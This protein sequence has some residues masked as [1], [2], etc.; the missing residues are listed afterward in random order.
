MGLAFVAS[1]AG[2]GTEIKIFAT[3]LGGGILLD[4]TIVR[5]VLAPAAVSILGRWNWWLP[6]RPARR[7]GS[8]RRPSGPTPLRDPL[9]RRRRSNQAPDWHRSRC[10][11]AV[12]TQVLGPPS[13][14]NLSVMRSAEIDAPSN[15]RRS[16]EE[17]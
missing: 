5:G 4:A 2:P 10:A 11:S 7:F 6:H 16:G 12:H 14:R 17:P 13:F 1:S 8:S 9:L 15:E 3:A